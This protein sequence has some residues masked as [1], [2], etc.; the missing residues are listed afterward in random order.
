MHLCQFD[1]RFGV[2]SCAPTEA[3]PQYQLMLVNDPDADF[4]NDESLFTA[5]LEKT[6]PS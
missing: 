2:A 5:S 3:Q 4:L 1:T 6:W